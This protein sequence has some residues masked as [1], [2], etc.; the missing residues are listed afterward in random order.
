VERG[1]GTFVVADVLQYRLGATTRFTAN[2]RQNHRAPTRVVLA[3]DE[4]SAS[5]VAADAL[6]IET[7]EPCVLLIVRGEANLAPISLGHNYFPTR[8]LPTILSVLAEMRRV[9][10]RELSITQALRAVGVEGYRRQRTQIGAR[11]PLLEESTSLR[12]ARTQPLIETES[13]DVSADGVPVTYAKTCFRAD[14][15]Q[16]VV[17]D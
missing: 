14:R 11:L 5:D 2:L 13:V 9:A 7:G 1:R 12:M 15:L 16:F 3:L 4:V 10:E 17:E 8:R 6:E